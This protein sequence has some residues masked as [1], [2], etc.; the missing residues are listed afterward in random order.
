MNVSEFC[1]EKE[2][3]ESYELRITL[4]SPSSPPPLHARHTSHLQP[5]PSCDNHRER[6]EDFYS[7]TCAT[8]IHLAVCAMERIFN[9]YASICSW[10]GGSGSAKIYESR[11]DLGSIQALILS[12]LQTA[13][14]SPPFTS[15]LPN[16]HPPCTTVFYKDFIRI[17]FLYK[18]DSSLAPLVT[19]E[20]TTAS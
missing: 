4:N 20:S 19:L 10:P 8:G 18:A 17:S 3:P 9:V 13:S 15:P 11:I 14:Y 7:T 12:Q 16:L 6:I 5:K 2:E 1:P